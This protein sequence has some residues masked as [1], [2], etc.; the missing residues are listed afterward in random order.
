VHPYLE[1][2]QQE[3]AAAI[4]GLSTEQLSQHPPGKW[5]AAE[6]LEH[7]YLTYTGTLKGFQRVT[8]AGK[9]LATTK[10]WTQRG[11]TLVVV[12]FGHLPSG[13]ESP[14]VARPRGLPAAKVLAEIGPKISEMDDGIARCEQRFGASRQL[15]DHPILGPLTGS[16]WRKFHLVHGLH[17]VKQIARLRQGGDWKATAASELG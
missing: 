6:V 11:R 2:L 14:P 10:T 1:T 17:H 9:P 12:T 8:E 16:Q 15:L 13:R 5:C 4:S 7:L 3:I